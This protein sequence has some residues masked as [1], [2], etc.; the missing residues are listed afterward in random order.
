MCLFYKHKILTLKTVCFKYMEPLK[1]N[2]QFNV[3][4]RGSTEGADKFRNNVCGAKMASRRKM[5][6]CG[7]GW[8]KVVEVQNLNIL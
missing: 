6:V 1:I 2:I 4:Q 8:L 3:K 5:D 7:Q